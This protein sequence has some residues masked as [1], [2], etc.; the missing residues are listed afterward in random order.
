MKLLRYGEPVRT[1]FGLLGRKEDDMTYALGFVAARSALF[2]S[3]LT[4]AVGGLPGDPEDGV[5]R[6]QQADEEGRTDVEIE[7]RDRFH[8]V[9]EA[10]RGSTLPTRQQLLRYVPRLRKSTAPHKRLVS[11]TNATAEFAK[12]T[13]SAEIQGIKVAHLPW[14]RVRELALSARAKEKNRNKNL[15]DEFNDYLVEILGMEDVRSNLVYVVSLSG[16]NEW[17]L[18]AR[19]IVNQQSRYFYPVGGRGGWPPPP[20]YMAFRYDSRL[21]TIHHVDGWTILTEPR[22]EFPKATVESVPP[23]YLLKLGPPIRPTKPTPNGPR[24]VRSGRVWCMIDLLLTCST[25]SEAL[26]E[27]KK[28]LGP[29]AKGLAQG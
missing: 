1:I 23:H 9:F 12:V 26:E 21:Q 10:K 18:N 16:G 7:W 5:V 11:I 13:L 2:A 14:R 4:R 17:G 15:L 24:I 27:T 28:R 20:N 25:I 8:A 3:A 29:G 6:L 19:D 22:S